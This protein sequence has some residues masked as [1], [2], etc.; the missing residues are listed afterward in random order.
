MTETITIDGLIVL[1]ALP[2]HAKS[3]APRSVLF[4]HGYFAEASVWEEW[5]PFFAERG[6]A[7]YAV[8][9]R[10]RRGSRPA[11]VLG[12]VSIEDF[13]NDA[14]TVAGTLGKP[15]VVGHSMGGLIAQL[16][17]ADDA[18][19]AAALIAP[20][21]PRGIPLFVP[22]LLLKQLKYVPAMLRS[23]VVRPAREDLRQIVMNRLSRDA[24]NSFLEKLHADSGRA[25]RQMSMTGVP[26]DAAR[27]HCPIRVFTASDDRFIPPRIVKR[28]AHRYGVEAEM[29]EGHGHA[30]IIE[31]GWQALAETIVEWLQRSS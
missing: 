3:A 29:L 6:F 4:V 5:L 26:V 7:A 23:R 1:R 18:V 16:L 24:Q 25:G 27:V 22:G 31:P 8:E 9:L 15:A 19:S 21:P 12:D 20:A 17:A 11:T 2:A 10:G 14:R 28:I 30:V 13:V